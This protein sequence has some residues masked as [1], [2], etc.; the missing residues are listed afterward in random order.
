MH[1]QITIGFDAAVQHTA[2]EAIDKIR[3][4][5]SHERCSIVGSNGDAMPGY[6]A[7]WCRY[8]HQT[9]RGYSLRAL[10]QGDE[11]VLINRIIENR[12]RE[13]EACIINAER[14]GHFS[15]MAKRI[16]AALAVETRAPFWA[17]Y[18]AAGT[19][20]A[21]SCVCVQPIGSQAAELLVGKRATVWWHTEGGQFV[22]FDIRKH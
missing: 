8:C 7:L 2:M 5:T 9:C 14:I 19:L 11:Q 15:S 1:V 21:G 3:P 16:E 13:K 6:I 10:R 4:S 18:S 17:T 22:D 20:P 12:K